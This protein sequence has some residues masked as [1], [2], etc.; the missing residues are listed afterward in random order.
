LAIDPDKKKCKYYIHL[1]KLMV[2][3]KFS[4]LE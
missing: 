2:N 1:P 4:L 3:P